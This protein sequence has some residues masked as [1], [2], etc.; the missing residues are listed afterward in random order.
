MNKSEINIL[1]TQ[2]HSMNQYGDWIDSLENNYIKYF[3][4]FGIKLFLISNATKNIDSIFQK[5]KPDGVI[6]SGGG[7]VNPELYN[8]KKK[9]NLSISKERDE[10]ETKIIKISIANNIPIL[11]ICRGMQFINVFFGG[12]IVQDISKIDSLKKHI[13]PGN[14]NIRILSKELIDCLKRKSMYTNVNSYHN[15]G[16][17][18]SLLGKDLKP[19]ALVDE[20]NLVEGLFHQYYPIAAVEWHPER[21]GSDKELD[22]F[23]I[24]TFLNRKLFWN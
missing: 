4:K 3:E 15:S 17:L 8:G 2:R 24:K 9:S 19:F 10:I 13:S 12:K 14:H 5:L 18:D 16:V 11:G 7:D 6:L 21:D 20:I 23:I 1:I 22:I